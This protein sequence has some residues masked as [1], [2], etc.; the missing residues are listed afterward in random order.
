MLR[1][2]PN[3]TTHCLTVGADLGLGRVDNCLGTVKK[4]M[5]IN[6][7]MMYFLLLIFFQMKNKSNKLVN[8]NFRFKYIFFEILSLPRA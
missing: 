4:I 1:K 8:N 5:S 2:L 3:G 6:S 7:T